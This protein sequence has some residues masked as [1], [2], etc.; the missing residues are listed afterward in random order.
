MHIK[1]KVLL[2][3]FRFRDS[4][5][6]EFLSRHKDILSVILRNKVQLC[7]NGLRG[8]FMLTYTEHITSWI[9]FEN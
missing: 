9:D 7:H 1:Y 4:K 2:I 3:S 8:I 5:D 6:L